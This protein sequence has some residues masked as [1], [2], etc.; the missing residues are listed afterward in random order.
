[1][2]PNIVDIFQDNRFDLD[3]IFQGQIQITFEYLLYFSLCVQYTE[4]IQY[5]RFQ[6]LAYLTLTHIPRLNLR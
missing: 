6:D 2:H 4:T 5:I 1:M 3:A